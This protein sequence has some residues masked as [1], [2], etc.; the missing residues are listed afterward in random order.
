MTDRTFDDAEQLLAQARQ[1]GACEEGLDWCR[2]RD[3]ED[4]LENLPHDYLLWCL[5]RGYTQFFDRCDLSRLSGQ[6]WAYLLRYQPQLIDRCD[7]G[8]LSGDDWAD[9]LLY[10]PQLAAY[11]PQPA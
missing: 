8:R 1:D 10:Q 5:A 6:R 2:G 3:L 4:I 9:L 11:G 7:T